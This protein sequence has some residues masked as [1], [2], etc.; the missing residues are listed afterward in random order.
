VYITCDTTKV[1]SNEDIT[2]FQDTVFDALK[3]DLEKYFNEQYS[4]FINPVACDLKTTIS[5]TL[6]TYLANGFVN[7][8]YHL[9]RF[10]PKNV[11]VCL[12]PF[13]VFET[14]S[15]G[16]SLKAFLRNARAYVEVTINTDEKEK[17]CTEIYDRLLKS[18]SHVARC[19][20]VNPFAR[21]YGLQV[22][23]CNGLLYEVQLEEAL[24]NAISKNTQHHIR[25]LAEYVY[26][27][28]LD[29]TEYSKKTKKFDFLYYAIKSDVESVIANVE[30]KLQS[31]QK[32]STII[33]KMAFE[34][35]GYLKQLNVANLVSFAEQQQSIP[36]ELRQD[37]L[38]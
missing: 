6:E 23:I 17:A 21:K 5:D 13:H 14:D 27:G 35:H 9:K 32:L 2:R 20:V 10:E 11:D 34:A 15:I 26:E 37:L 24:S 8:Y 38:K 33:R 12:E 7:I 36:K 28:L 16:C 25:S 4:I 29:G 19:S 18:L 31:L 3:D 1:L 30:K 22:W